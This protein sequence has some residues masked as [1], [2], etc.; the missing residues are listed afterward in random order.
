MRKTD[1]AKLTAKPS[2]LRS[3]FPT[4]EAL[5][6]NIKLAHFQAMMWNKCT[7]GNP[8]SE[9]PC[10]VSIHYIFAKQDSSRMSCIC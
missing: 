8:S 9:D 7:S 4:D 5:E 10:H 3:L 6:L 1:G 2:M